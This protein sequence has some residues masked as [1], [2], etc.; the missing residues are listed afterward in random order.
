MKVFLTPCFRQK[1]GKKIICIGG[2]A[3]PAM[4]ESNAMS[5]YKKH[6]C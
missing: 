2:M 3:A 4:L 6:C 1:G 5:L